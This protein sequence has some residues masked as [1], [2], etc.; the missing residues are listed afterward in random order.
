M[1]QTSRLEGNFEISRGGWVADF[2][3]PVGFLAAFQSD[4]PYNRSNYVDE[5][6]DDLVSLAN[7][8][9]GRDHFR[10]L[11]EAEEILM[12]DM[13]F[14]PIYHY[15]DSFLISPV[16]Q[17]WSRSVLGTLDFSTARIER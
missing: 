13:P 4:N 10:A 3:D 1:F 12:A 5:E 7:V 2:P 15:T 6:F 9:G 16:L 11:Y 17:D 14:I 8:V